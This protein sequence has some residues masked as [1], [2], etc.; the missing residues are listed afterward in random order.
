MRKTPDWTTLTVGDRHGVILFASPRALHVVWLGEAALGISV[1]GEHAVIFQI[2]PAKACHL[3][4]D[5]GAF[6][7]L[8]PLQ[9]LGKNIYTIDAVID[10]IRDKEA[11]RKLQATPFEII[12][13]EP[14]LECIQFVTQFSKKT[15][16]YPSLSA[17]DLK[18]LAL[19][20]Q[21][22]KEHVGTEHIRSEPV[23]R[24]HINNK[25]GIFNHPTGQPGWFGFH[26][27]KE[28][29]SPKSSTENEVVG[30]KEDDSDI[31]GAVQQLS[32]VT[33][34]EEKK[35]NSLTQ[36]TSHHGSE[37]PEVG[38]SQFREQDEAATNRSETD[39]EDDVKT[40]VKEDTELDNDNDDGSSSDDD[41][42]GDWITPSNVQEMK[43]QFMKGQEEAEEIPVA[44]ITTDYAMQNMLIQMN[45]QLLSLNGMVIKEVRTFI[46]RCIACFHTTNIMTKVF[47]PHC[48]HKTLKR[49]A[50]TVKPDGSK[51]L[52]ISKRKT[53]NLRGTKYSLPMPKGGKHSNNPILCVDQPQAQKRPTKASM[54]KLNP[55]DPDYIAGLSPFAIRDVHSRAAQ[56]GYRGETKMDNPHRNPNERR[57][58][59][60]RRKKKPSGL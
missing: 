46:L 34:E 36:D 58:I 59:K 17:T 24:S 60:S 40:G 13:K 30:E 15:G 32:L 28:K 16:D 47:C 38:S 6:I 18:V 56:R 51:V 55:L 22:E 25:S 27:P 48:G 45:L 33:S 29:E 37:I 11:R 14:S 39:Q 31:A 52:H 20:L 41:D 49:V 43:N 21:L 19:T 23:Q 1:I 10:E 8:T 42:G 53:L 4:V 12:F 2:M 9:E 54:V 7:S 26:L 3:V 5:S 44:C 50:V 57:K 35:E